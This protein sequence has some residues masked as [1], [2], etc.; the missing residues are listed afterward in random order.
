VSGTAHRQD[1]QDA[2]QTLAEGNC[3][4]AASDCKLEL[5]G[6]NTCVAIAVSLIDGKWGDGIDPN[7]EKAEDGAIALCRSVK[8]KN[9]VVQAASCASDDLRL[10]S[11]AAGAG[12]NRQLKRKYI[13][14]LL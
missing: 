1:S 7:R 2:T 5:S 14:R 9:C 6:K 4:S 8:G 3:R 10:P 11:P 13:C 12:C